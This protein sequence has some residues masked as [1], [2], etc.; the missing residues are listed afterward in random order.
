MLI[1]HK[2]NIL[3]LIIL[4]LF[5]ILKNINKNDKLLKSPKFLESYREKHF[6]YINVLKHFVILMY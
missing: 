6:C 4:E 1:I 3:E 5:F 2:L